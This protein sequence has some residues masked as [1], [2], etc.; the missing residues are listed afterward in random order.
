MA[1][2]HRKRNFHLSWERHYIN[3]VVMLF[4][5]IINY[6]VGQYVKEGNLKSRRNVASRS[7]LKFPRSSRL[8]LS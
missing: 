7:L 8:A 1:Y 3:Y 2:A 5:F 4:F 6:F